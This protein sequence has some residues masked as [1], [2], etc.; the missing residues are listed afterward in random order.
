MDRCVYG[1]MKY[2]THELMNDDQCDRGFLQLIVIEHFRTHGDTF[3]SLGDTS[4]ARS[5]E[6]ISYRYTLIPVILWNF[7]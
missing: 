3:F 1:A 2:I 5:N 7:G 6:R 4:I